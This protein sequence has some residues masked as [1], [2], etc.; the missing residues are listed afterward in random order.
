MAFD[1][2]KLGDLNKAVDPA[3][4]PAATS[5]PSTRLGRRST[6][7]TPSATSKKSSNT[8]LAATPATKRAWDYF[9][10]S[11]SRK[12]S[13]KALKALDSS[14]HNPM[15]HY[16]LGVVHFLEGRTDKSAQE[17]RDALN[18]RP[19]FPEAVDRLVS[20]F[21]HLNKFDEAKAFLLSLV[22]QTTGPT[23]ARAVL[24]L[25]RIYDLT[26][27]VDRAID[28]LRPAVSDNPED[29]EARY[30]L[31]R[32]LSRRAKMTRPSAT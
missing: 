4:P 19:D 3:P 27:Q 29:V 14:L 1:E 12:R 18:G 31:T 7:R 5:S 22:E 30:L 15:A 9:Y 20:V 23:R 28:L 32:L 16:V 21:A 13:K 11:A 24:E 8:P 26:D 25:S 2:F 17:L 10:R 6:P